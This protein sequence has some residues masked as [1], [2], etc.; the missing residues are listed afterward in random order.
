M[1]INQIKVIFYLLYSTI[2]LIQIKIY[3]KIHVQKK[4]F[5]KY[6]KYPHKGLVNCI[7]FASQ[8]QYCIQRKSKSNTKQFY[9]GA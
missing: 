1:N 4:I 3:T 6:E 5:R 2:K 9:E 8:S 7:I